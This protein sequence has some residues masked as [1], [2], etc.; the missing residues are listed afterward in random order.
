MLKVAVTGVGGGCGQG[1]LQALHH[2]SLPTRVYAVDVT[3]ESA[4]LHFS[5]VI[6]KVLPKPELNPEAWEEFVYEQSIDAIIPGSDHD[7]LPLAQHRRLNGIVSSEDFVDI[8]NSKSKTVLFS[9]VRTPET[10]IG[11]VNLDDPDDLIHQLNDMYPLVIKPSFG[12]TSRGVHVVQNDEELRFY[13]KRTEKPVIQRYVGGTEYTCALFFDVFSQYRFGFQMRRTLYAGTTY[14]A[15]VTHDPVVEAFMEECGRAF[16]QFNPFG[17][18]NIQIK[19][20]DGRAYLIEI[21]ARASGSTAI[22]AFFG[23]N[24]P[25]MMLRH[26][27]MKEN[28]N[29]PHTVEG[30]ALRY[31]S[32]VIIPSWSR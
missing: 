14:T 29:R 20:E 12:M 26:F 27:V 15:E 4:G 6:P 16:E 10:I 19:V 31:W 11:D 3:K 23:Y 18:V 32:A 25:E 8:A 22:R 5:G 7:L 13:L 21:N 24:E 1:I 30:Q 9:G 28:F 2:S 17:A